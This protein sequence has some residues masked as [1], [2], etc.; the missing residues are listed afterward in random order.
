MIGG[1]LFL[2]LVLFAEDIESN[3][4]FADFF[5]RMANHSLSG[6]NFPIY[7]LVLLSEDIENH[8]DVAFIFCLPIPHGVYGDS[9]G[10]FLGKVKDSGGNA[11]KGDGVD[12]IFLSRIKAGFVAACKKLAVFLGKMIAHDWSHS[13]NH[14]I[15][16]QIKSPGDFCLSGWL[17]MSL[18]FHNVGTDSPQLD[19]RKSVNAIIDAGVTGLPATSHSAVGSIYYCANFKCGDVAPPKI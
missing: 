12:F 19:S 9:G 1:L 16:G 2:A 14:I 11:A 4:R 5:Y 13:V 17:L 7:F 10:F 8:F 15:A 3:L 18:L 6:K